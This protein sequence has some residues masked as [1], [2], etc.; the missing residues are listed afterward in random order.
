MPMNDRELTELVASR[1]MRWKICP[2]RFG[3]SG[4]SW[5]PR[6][7]FQP[8]VELSEA[9]QVLDR[10]ADHYSLTKDRHGIFT[11]TVQIGACRGKVSGESK[12]RTV[13]L[14]VARAL[15]LEV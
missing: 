13:T 12:A 6:W 14:A 9:F 4:K 11:A 15:G 2:D 8:L 7:R 5:I 10:A 1:V 3:K